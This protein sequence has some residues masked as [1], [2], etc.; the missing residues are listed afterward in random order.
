MESMAKNLISYS[1][2]VNLEPIFQQSQTIKFP[3][4]LI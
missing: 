4:T 2:L 3:L 1:F